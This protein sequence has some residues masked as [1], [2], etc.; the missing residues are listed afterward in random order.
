MVQIHSP[1][2]IP[3]NSVPIGKTKGPTL[4][5][6]KN[7]LRQEWGTPK[8]KSVNPQAQIFAASLPGELHQWYA[9][10]VLGGQEQFVERL[11]HPSKQQINVQ[12][13]PPEKSANGIIRMSGA[14]MV[15]K[16]RR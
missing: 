4:D 13:T 16:T 9:L 7:R 3:L 8:T 14:G 12:I 5:S 6:V 1:Q 15:P 11:G 10:V 2:P